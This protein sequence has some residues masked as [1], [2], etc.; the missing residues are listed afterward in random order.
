ML[1]LL[2]LE[3]NAIDLILSWNGAKS[4]EG[5]IGGVGVK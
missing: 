4:S 5:M 2:F 1:R 3:S